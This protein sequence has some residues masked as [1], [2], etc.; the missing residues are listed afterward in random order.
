MPKVVLTYF[1]RCGYTVASKES[2]TMTSTKTGRKA[3]RSRPRSKTAN[4]APLTKPV[5]LT[6]KVDS[7]TYIKLCTLGATQRRTNQDLLSEAVQQYL[8]RASTI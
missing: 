3:A 6:V 7:K 4:A 1:R 8:D 2:G 5:A